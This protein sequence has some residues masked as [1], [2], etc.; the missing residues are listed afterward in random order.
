MSSTVRAA[1]A[2]SSE[3]ARQ[4]LWPLLWIGIA[5]YVLVAALVI[6][7]AVAASP[8]W[9]L[10]GIVPTTLFCVALAV[11]IGVY[12]TARRIAPDMN[13]QQKKATKK[14]VKLVGQTAEHL[15]TPR[16]ILIFHVIRDVVWPPKTGQ[17]L[18][19]ELADTPGE[20]RRSFEALRKL[21]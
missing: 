1:R 4:L 13:T 3:F 12:V 19:G 21:F 14:V 16:F 18:I 15:G 10:L 8:W 20:L 6:W 11:W 7:I 2:V 17:T 5:A 9:L